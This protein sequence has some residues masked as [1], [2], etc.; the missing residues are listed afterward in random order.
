MKKTN[1]KDRERL[2]ADIARF[3]ANGGVI[4][5]IPL[6][7]SGEQRVQMKSKAGRQ[8]YAEGDDESWR[9]YDRVAYEKRNKTK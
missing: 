8:V 9:K 1:E 4:T 7:M 2:A 6:G 3:T 5:D